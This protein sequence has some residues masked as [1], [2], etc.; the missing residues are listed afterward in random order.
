LFT[1]HRAIVLVL[2][3]LLASCIPARYSQ[4][5]ASCVKSST[6]ST[7]FSDQR[8]PGK[9]S[10]VPVPMTRRRFFLDCGR[11]TLGL[12]SISLVGR[13][14]LAQNDTGAS[15]SSDWQALILDL[16][17]R[18]PALLAQSPTV[19]AVSMALV[20][21]AKLMWRGSFGVKDLDSRTPIGPDTVFE[22]G[23]VSKTVFAYVVMK[24]CEKGV[25]DLDMP[26]TNYTPDRIIK[27]DSRLDLIT[28]RRVLSHT[29]GFQN[30]RSAKEPLAIRFTPGERWSYS[31]EGYSYLQSVV[32]H[33]AGHV[34]ASDCRT[35]DDGA[36]GCTTDFDAYMKANLLVPFGM[37]SSGYLYREGM[38]RPYD[39]KGTLIGDRKAT[40]IDAARYGSAGGLHTTPAEYA[41][42]LIEVIKPKPSDAYRLNAGSLS[43]MLRSQIKVTDSLSWGLGWA[44]EHTKAGDLIAHSGDNPGYKALAAAS[45]QQQ[46]GFII[47]TNGDAGYDDII[48]K[49]VMSEP[50]QRFLPT[51]L[52]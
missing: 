32:T 33:L 26:L 27:G 12:S 8:L 18:L 46:S 6:V 42:F 51:A 23:S 34:N 29:A 41:K 19:P 30:W 52:V 17:K 16:E 50:M 9:L 3:A 45:L 28:T 38:A 4:N 43:E 7:D 35:F 24:L 47:M 37:T 14:A 48:A 25:L 49:V 20:A 11:T 13:S 2:V 31:G 21:D 5:V 15:T 39:R 1:D 22:A 44:I 36:R 10:G 40:A